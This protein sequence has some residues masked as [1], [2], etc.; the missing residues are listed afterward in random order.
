MS[1]H[2]TSQICTKAFQFENSQDQYCACIGFLFEGDADPLKF[3]KFSSGMTLKEC[4][5][6]DH[7]LGPLE[8]VYEHMKPADLIEIIGRRDQFL[9]KNKAPGQA[10]KD[11]Q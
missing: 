1:W 6:K 8:K 9:Q 3:F 10:P 7:F 2:Q 4:L 11:K 5:S